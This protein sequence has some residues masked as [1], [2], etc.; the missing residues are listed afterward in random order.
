MYLNFTLIAK[1]SMKQPTNRKPI[2]F[3]T[4]VTEANASK[5]GQEKRGKKISKIKDR[6]GG[7]DELWSGLEVKEYSN[8]A[9][10]NWKAKETYTEQFL[11][12]LRDLLSTNTEM[13]PLEVA[14]RLYIIYDET[15][16]QR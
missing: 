5:T 10:L 15:I 16:G 4:F 8:P 13:T 11:D 2:S 14:Q 1:E 6:T 9:D 12:R 3:S 7:S